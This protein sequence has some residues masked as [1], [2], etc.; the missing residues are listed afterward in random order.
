[1][2]SGIFDPAGQDDPDQIKEDADLARDV[3]T[4]AGLTH[5]DAVRDPGGIKKLIDKINANVE[6]GKARDAARQAK[7]GGGGKKGR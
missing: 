5:K 2:P 1:M 7:G 4:V 6:R 3:N